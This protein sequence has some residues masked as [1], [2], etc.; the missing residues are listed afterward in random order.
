MLQG[1]DSAHLQAMAFGLVLV[2]PIQHFNLS[3][4]HK[5]VMHVL[6][7]L[8]IQL[9]IHVALLAIALVVNIDALH[10]IDC[11]PLEQVTDGP[12]D[13]G[14]LQVREHQ[15]VKGQLVPGPGPVCDSSWAPCL[16]TQTQKAHSE[17]AYAKTM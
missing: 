4:L 8:Y 15:I 13:L 9:Q 11:V 10:K 1:N 6:T 16:H 17:V 5:G 7:A 3:I 14:V 12:L 2:L